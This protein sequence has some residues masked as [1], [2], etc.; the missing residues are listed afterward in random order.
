[1]MAASP[2]RKGLL[3][4]ELNRLSEAL[5]VFDKLIADFGDDEGD[6]VPEV[7]AAA[8]EVREQ[9]GAEIGE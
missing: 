9:L 3:L 2:Y 5:L 6:L 7:V 4:G 1:M 8:R